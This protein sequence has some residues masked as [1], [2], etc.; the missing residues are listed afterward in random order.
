MNMDRAQL[1]AAMQATADKPPVPVVTKEWGTVFVR[2]LTVDEADSLQGQDATGA[3]DKRRLARGACRLICDETG[4]RL[5]DANNE[6][7]VG[8]LAR[9][10]WTLLRKVLSAAD[11]DGGQG[12]V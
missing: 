4:Q 1:I 3:K 11:D 9:Q 5:F 6:D 12:N 10:P 2:P 8:L 7:D